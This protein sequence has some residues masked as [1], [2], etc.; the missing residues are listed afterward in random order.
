MR[1]GHLEEAI[2]NQSA[3]TVQDSQSGG[4]LSNQ[5][6]LYRLPPQIDNTDATKTI[7]K[8]SFLERFLASE[9]SLGWSSPAVFL[10]EVML[11]A[12]RGSVLEPAIQALWMSVM[13][14]MVSNRDL[15][16]QGNQ[17]YSR[18]LR[19]FHRRLSSTEVTIDDEVLATVEILALYEVGDIKV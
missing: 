2:S 9:S 11:S 3:P 1:R 8:G 17:S 10:K 14:H 5:P 12:S 7:L 19:Q 18:S 4:T 6:S 13:G 15:S 16:V